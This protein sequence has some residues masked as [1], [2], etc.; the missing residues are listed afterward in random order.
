ADEERLR[1]RVRLNAVD[2]RTLFGAADGTSRGYAHRS[3][4]KRPCPHPFH[5]RSSLNSPTETETLLKEPKSGSHTRVVPRAKSCGYNM[6]RRSMTACD[7]A[8]LAG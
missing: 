2:R 7:P 8:P 6:I 3:H 5:R 1:Q 4:Q